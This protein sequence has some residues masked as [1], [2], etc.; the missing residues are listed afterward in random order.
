VSAMVAPVTA[1]RGRLA[2]MDAVRG[3]AILLVVTFHVEVA[4]TILYGADFPVWNAVNGALAPFRMPTLGLRLTENV[5][6]GVS[7]ALVAGLWAPAV[8][9]WAAR[10][11]RLV[12]ALFVFPGGRQPGRERTVGR[13]RLALPPRRPVAD[14][15]DLSGA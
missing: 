5:A 2:W 10:R 15:A 8:A 3:G 9:V 11:W 14:G 1:G 12:D 13:E 6:V 4:V 7:V